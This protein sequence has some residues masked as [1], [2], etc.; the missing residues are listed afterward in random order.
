MPKQDVKAQIT[1]AA[2]VCFARN[3]VENTSIDQIAREMKASKGKV[4]HWF[5]TKGE[6]LLSVRNQSIVSVL[7]RVQPI[8]DTP[9]PTAER[10]LRM[11][12]AH[13]TGILEDLPFHRVVVENLRSGQAGA[14]TE[15]ERA[16]LAEIVALQA[17]YEDL[18][19]EL[20]SAGQK[21][22]SF[23][24]QSTSIAVNSVIVLLNAPIFWYQ[25][26][27]D[28]THEQRQEI[29]AQIARMAL[30]AI[31]APTGQQYLQGF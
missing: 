20:V 4:Y 7:E 28:E 9:A 6:L 21:D 10:F 17:S 18:F 27:T 26:R 3:G 29:A 13:V 19:R 2:A 14:T 24:Q 30:G 8:A 5:R 1:R 22:G 11:A 25:P 15:H 12:E 16:F 23:R 31:A